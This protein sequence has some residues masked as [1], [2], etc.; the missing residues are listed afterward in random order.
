MANE[1]EVKFK[2]DS[3]AAIRRRL[4]AI[5]ASYCSAVVQEDNYFDTSTR[6]LLAD[7]VGLRVREIEVLRAAKGCRPDDR[8]QLTYKGPLHAH[9]KAKVRREVQTHFE[10]PGAVEDVLL[11]LGHH[12][13]M[14]FQKRR[15]TYRLGRCL[16]ELDELPLIGSFVEIEGPSERQVFTIARKL[17]LPGE[18]TKASYAHLMTDACRAAGRKPVGIKLP[19]RKK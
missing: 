8:P 12:I 4:R 5:E 13:V 11:A 16:I 10:T 1:I 6:A 3:H 18:P 9:R 14:S 19:R 17:G 15:T 2:V 7:Q